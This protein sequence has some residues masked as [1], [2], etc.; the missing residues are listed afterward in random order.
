[1]VLKPDPNQ[2]EIYHEGR[3][4]RLLVGALVF[5]RKSKR[6]ALTYDAKYLRQKQS[7]P[8]GPELPLTKQVH[9]SKPNELFPSFADRI[10]SRENPA[11]V[12]YCASAGIDIDETNP[13]ILLG[14]I[15]RRGPSTF[16]FESVYRF[17]RNSLVAQLRAFR[18]R[19]GISLWEFASAFDVPYPTM[20][21]IEN[22]KSKD[23]LTMRLV[24]TYLAFP[25]VAR[26]Q[27]R[28]SGRHVNRASLAKLQQATS[29]P[30]GTSS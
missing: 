16:V 7:V 21:R 30:T 1:M 24:Q 18:E 17:D 6:F 28:L 19:L 29:G 23:L 12:D 8:L 3:R 2:L 15:G 20:Q 25:E 13:I 5:N 14:A 10:P 4:R 9:Q 22:G 26:S 27:L 11:Y